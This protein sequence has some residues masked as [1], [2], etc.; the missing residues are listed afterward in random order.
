MKYDCR[1]TMIK[2]GIAEQSL[3]GGQAVAESSGRATPEIMREVL[4]SYRKAQ[5]RSC[6]SLLDSTPRSTGRVL[7]G[8]SP[9]D[10][11]LDEVLP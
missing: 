6:T 1:V 10:D 7:K 5:A 3:R 4:E 9:T 11:L 8:L 2:K